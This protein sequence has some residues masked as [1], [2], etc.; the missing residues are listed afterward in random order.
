MLFL[1]ISE[2]ASHTVTCIYVLRKFDYC[3]Y[4][5]RIIQNLFNLVIELF[6]QFDS[7]LILLDT[8]AAARAFECNMHKHS[9]PL[10]LRITQKSKWAADLVVS[11]YY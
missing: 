11:K 4:Y 5:A 8:V 6:A 9:R 1:D 10:T 2:S 7:V 3:Q